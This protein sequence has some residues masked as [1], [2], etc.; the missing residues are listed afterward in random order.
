VEVV[1]D[2]SG[3][4]PEAVSGG[5]FGLQIMRERAEDVGGMLIVD[6]HIGKG[7]T[8]RLRLPLL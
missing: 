8:I 7:T 1:D 5:H 6:S 3:F 2:G 4:Q